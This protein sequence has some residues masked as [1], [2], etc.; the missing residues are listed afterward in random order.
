MDKLNFSLTSYFFLL[1]M[2]ISLICKAQVK[3]TPVEFLLGNKRIQG[4]T[5]LTKS[6]PQSKFGI[7]SITTLAGDY[8]NQD[9]TNNEVVSNVQLNYDIFKG[10]KIASGASFNSAKGFSPII[11]VQYQYVKNVMFIINPTFELNTNVSFKTFALIEYAPK[12]EKVSIYTRL[13]GMY[14]QNLATDA[15]ERSFI[16]G[17]LGIFYKG[18]AVGLGVNQDYYGALK[19]SKTNTGLF[20]HYKFI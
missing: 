15:H 16:V 20:L 14:I 8:K 12:K 4:Q 17:R 10:I 5:I 7:F 6:F 2:F 11:G 3:P 9:R 19:I 1:S 13:Q 18:F